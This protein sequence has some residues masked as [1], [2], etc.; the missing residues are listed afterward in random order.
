MPNQYLYLSSKNSENHADFNCDLPNGLR[1]LPYSQLRVLSCRLNIDANVLT[2]DSTNNVFY[3]G[4]DHWNKQGSIIPLLP[5][6]MVNGEY[7]VT[8]PT[9]DSE[10]CDMLKEQINKALLPYCFAR[11]GASVSMANRKLTFNLS[12]MNMYTCPTVDLPQNVIDYWMNKPSNLLPFSTRLP[13]QTGSK[14]MPTS[15]YPLLGTT[16]VDVSFDT[17]T[18]KGFSLPKLGDQIAYHISAPIVSGITGGTI[19]SPF[20]SHVINI[21]FA[22]IS[23]EENVDVEATPTTSQT[24]D[25]YRFCFGESSFENCSN[26]VI[27]TEKLNDAF[28]TAGKQLSS[29][30]VYNLELTNQYIM[31]AMNTNNGTVVSKIPVQGVY[32]R[33]SKFQIQYYLYDTAYGSFQRLT[34]LM[35][36]EGQ[37]AWIPLDF[38][39]DNGDS[40]EDI[41]CDISR[42]QSSQSNDNLAILMYTRMAIVPGVISY[43]MACDDLYNT[44]VGFIAGN[45]AGSF[46]VHTSKSSNI[47]RLMTILTDNINATDV[48]KVSQTIL[49]YMVDAQ[50]NASMYD[51]QNDV[52]TEQ[53]LNLDP[54]ADMLSIDSTSGIGIQTTNG[55]HSIGIVSQTDIQTSGI[56]YPLFYVSIPSLPI[57]NFS[58]SDSKGIENQFVCAVEL[59]QSQSSSFYTSKIYTEQYNVLQNAQ[60]IEVDRIRIRICDI[61]SVAVEALKKYTTLVIEIKDDARIEQQMLFKNLK[62]YIDRRTNV[63]QIIDYQ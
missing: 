41:P 4:V 24:Q 63:P 59:E 1:I 62:D 2:I 12:G 10:L 30:Q 47:P 3:L 36:V 61:D 44:G 57:K 13:P 32:R 38:T 52:L 17:D 50:D 27:E 49:N 40:I 34:V 25:Y 18:Y 35:Q 54:S 45:P 26:G 9:A 33:K 39:D 31:L 14:R 58:A 42:Q 16:T 60:D 43:T 56:D 37:G 48:N 11:G 51:A 22:G 7:D 46:G 6:T 15:F 8:Q 53:L 20:I 5:I 19:L 21:N 28:S 55:S 29:K 23:D